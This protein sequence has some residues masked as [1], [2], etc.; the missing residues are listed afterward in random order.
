M[1]VADGLSVV[2]ARSAARNATTVSA[3]PT[4]CSKHKLVIFH[5]FAVLNI[6]L[7]NRKG[8]RKGQQGKRRAKGVIA[9]VLT[10]QQEMTPFAPPFAPFAVV[11]PR[12][13]NLDPCRPCR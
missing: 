11:F 12:P 1:G 2:T 13:L 3:Q 8:K 4:A 5:P 10:E 9:F 7:N 6:R